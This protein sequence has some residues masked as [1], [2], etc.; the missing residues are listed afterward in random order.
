MA[1]SSTLAIGY[2]RTAT[3]TKTSTVQTTATQAQRLQQYC[4]SSGIRLV[5]SFFDSGVSGSILQREGLHR[6]L[7]M[8][9]NGNAEVLI[10]VSLSRLTRSVI[11]LAALLDAHFGDGMHGLISI[12][13]GLDTRS[14]QG[15]AALRF[16]CGISCDPAEGCCHA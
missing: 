12:D 10:V 16:L 11:M 9:T 14:D 5:D 3:L 15:R 7:G 4:T 1:A 2:I 13:E 8:L 6:A